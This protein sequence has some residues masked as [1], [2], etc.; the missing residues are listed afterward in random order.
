VAIGNGWID[1]KRQ[2]LSYLDYSMKMGLLEENSE[3]WKKT[4][5]LTEECEKALENVKHDPI[6]IDVCQKIVYAVINKKTSKC[7]WLGLRGASK[8]DRDNHSQ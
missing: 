4:K 5:K 3:D 7:V 8:A 1:A 6:K 2:S